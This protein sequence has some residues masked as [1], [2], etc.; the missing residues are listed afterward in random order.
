M[1]SKVYVSGALTGVENPELIKA[2]YER[3]GQLCEE[4]GLA[5]HIPHQ[6]TDPLLHPHASVRE[7]YEHDR[8]HVSTADFVIAFGGIPS[9]GVGQ[10][11]EIAKANGVPV[12][13]LCERAKPLSRMTRGSPNVVA[14]IRYDDFTEALYQVRA[15]FR[16][17]L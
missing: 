17:D 6:H 8:H 9:L 4:I 12:L 3:I 5:I 7:V 13:L 16:G 10:E 11:I 14:E 2:N 15:F 1:R